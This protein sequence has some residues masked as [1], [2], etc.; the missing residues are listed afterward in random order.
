MKD[1]RPTN[2]NRSGSQPEGEPIE[3]TV[4]EA[5]RLLLAQ[6]QDKD[7]DRKLALKQLASLYSDTRRYDQALGCLRELMAIEPE[8]EQ[9]AACVL[10]MGATAEKKQDFEAAVGFYRE[11]LAMEPIRNDVWYF[12]HNNLGHSLNMLGYFA[13]GE[14]CCRAAIEINPSRPNGHKNLGISLAGQ[15][16]YREAARCFVTAR[17]IPCRGRSLIRLIE[18]LAPAAPG[19]GV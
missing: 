11:A 2:A 1:E 13:E 9:K 6:L 16:H 8:L 19:T 15:G 18:G 3:I 5:E 10:V 7:K 14:K 4:E 12:I 17:R